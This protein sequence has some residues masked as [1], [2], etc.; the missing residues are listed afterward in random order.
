MMSRMCA[1]RLS[2]KIARTRISSTSARI[3]C[4]NQVDHVVINSVKANEGVG[5]PY[6]RVRQKDAFSRDLLP[7]IGLDEADDANSLRRNAEAATT[8]TMYPPELCC[9]LAILGV[10]GVTERL[11]VGS[12][13]LKKPIALPR[14][15][16]E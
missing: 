9:G 8:G 13:D 10:V 15:P 14:K 12:S 6:P 11:W 3:V 4:M 5:L 7:S 2:E 1:L 16:R